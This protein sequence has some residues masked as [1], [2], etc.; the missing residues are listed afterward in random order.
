VSGLRGRTLNETHAFLFDLD[1]TQVVSVYRHVLAWREPL[2]RGGLKLAVWRIHPRIGMSGKLF[3]NALLGRR[4]S[5]NP[6]N[7]GN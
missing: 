5:A 2:E 1:G 6:F 4:I 3:V 7:N